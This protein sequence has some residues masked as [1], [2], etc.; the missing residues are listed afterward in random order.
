MSSSRLIAIYVIIV[1]GVGIH[2]PY[3]IA[4]RKLRKRVLRGTDPYGFGSIPYVPSQK[5]VTKTFR[6]VVDYLFVE[7]PGQQ[8][9]KF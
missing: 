6:N 1:M 3:V 4:Q 8:C 2:M 9:G 5:A 7:L